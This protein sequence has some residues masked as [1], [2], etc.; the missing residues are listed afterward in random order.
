[1][2]NYEKYFL[3]KKPKHCSFKKNIFIFST[4]RSKSYKNILEYTEANNV[5]MVTLSVRCN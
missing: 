4:D 3:E 1:M 5:V 2:K